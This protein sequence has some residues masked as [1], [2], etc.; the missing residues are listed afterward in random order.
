MSYMPYTPTVIVM[1]VSN[2]SFI[3]WH[4]FL[5]KSTWNEHNLMEGHQFRL[6]IGGLLW[7]FQARF[8]RFYSTLIPYCKKKL[9]KIYFFT[10]SVLVVTTASVS[11]VQHEFLGIIWLIYS[12]MMKLATFL[13]SML[14]ICSH[15]EC[16]C[17]KTEL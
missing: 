6:K 16:N 10:M 7:H 1:I 15:K 11:K 13:V 4:Y 14:S 5:A 3:E 8:R 12:Y 9:V 2:P 17:T